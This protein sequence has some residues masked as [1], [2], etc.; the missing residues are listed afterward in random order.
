MANEE[1][2]LDIQ[3]LACER[4]Y[5][6]FRDLDGRKDDWLPCL[7]RAIGKYVAWGAKFKADKLRAVM[8]GS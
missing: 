6:T 2:F 8:G 5:E 3:A 4:M 1:G 7:Q